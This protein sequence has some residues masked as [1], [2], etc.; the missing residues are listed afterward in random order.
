MLRRPDPRIRA[1]GRGD[2]RRASRPLPHRPDA[3]HAI[4]NVRGRASLNGVESADSTAHPR[5]PMLAPVKK[6]P[7]ERRIV[8][9]AC[10]HDCPDTCALAVTVEDGVAVKVE[11]A[12]DHPFTAGTLCTKVARYLE[13]TYSKDRV[14]FPQR[15]TGPKGKGGFE[16]ISWDEALATIAERFRAIEADD[17]QGI[18]PYDYAGTMGYVQW[19]SMGRRFFNRLGASRSEERRVGKSVDLGGGRI[20]KGKK[21]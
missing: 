16:R 20:F 13:R 14:L 9:A 11:G 18:L 12:K 10:P 8:R 2:R 15:R 19:H 3:A 1:D 7:V 4:R 21:M 17:P 5:S 6:A